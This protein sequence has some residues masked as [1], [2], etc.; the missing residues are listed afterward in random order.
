[1]TYPYPPDESTPIYEQILETIPVRVVGD[2]TLAVTEELEAAHADCSTITPMTAVP[3]TGQML[4]GL[5]LD[6]LRKRA[7][8]TFG[9]PTPTPGQSVTTDGSQTSPTALTVITSQALAGGTYQVSWAV[10]LGGTLSAADANNFGLYVGA[11]QVAQSLNPAVAG[12]Y[13]QPV[14]E[15]IIPAGGATLSI[16]AIG[17]STVGAVYTAQ[18]TT[19]LQG[20]PVPGIVWVCHSIQQ[21]LDQI[22]QGVSQNVGAQFLTGT[23][24]V[25]E[26]TAPLWFVAPAGSVAVVGIVAERRGSA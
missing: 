10:E 19:A 12:T 2:V 3:A 14:E 6:I 20:I 25:Y 21:A 8:L 11:T 13:P 17:N 22:K 1:M 15:I 7:V 18:L 23:A 4:P 5:P 9:Q 26:A 24:F 16:K